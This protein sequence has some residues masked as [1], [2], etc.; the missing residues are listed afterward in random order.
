MKSAQDNITTI[1]S[2]IHKYLDKIAVEDVDTLS[3]N[4]I[5]LQ[6]FVNMRQ[7]IPPYY[8]AIKVNRL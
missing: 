7:T 4:L 6:N 2:I 3:D 5:Q 1:L 8:D